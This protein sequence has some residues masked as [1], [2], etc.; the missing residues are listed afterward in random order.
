[1]Q[2]TRDFTHINPWFLCT[3]SHY[4]TILIYTKCMQKIQTVQSN[5]DVLWIFVIPVQILFNSRT[6]YLNI[7]VQFLIRTFACLP[8]CYST[9][10]LKK[11]Y[12][13]FAVPYYKMLNDVIC[14]LYRTINTILLSLCG[15]VK[16]CTR[17]PILQVGS[18]VQYFT[19]PPS[20]GGRYCLNT[21]Q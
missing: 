10:Q 18:L 21:A 6:I 19:I 12:K 14:L 1:M 3:D 16:Y 9:I 17:D 20:F 4:F 8:N 11:P 5:F 13:T 2:K 15:V 7:P